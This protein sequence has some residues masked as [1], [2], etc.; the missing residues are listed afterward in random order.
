MYVRT[1]NETRIFGWLSSKCWPDVYNCCQLC[2]TLWLTLSMF[3][4]WLHPCPL[5]LMYLCGWSAIGSAWVGAH[6]ARG[7]FFHKESE[8][9]GH[10]AWKW[11]SCTNPICNKST[12]EKSLRIPYH[13]ILC[14][15]I[16]LCMCAYLN[17]R[18]TWYLVWPFNISKVY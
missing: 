12:G 7:F 16:M 11:Q 14:C 10:Y 18:S 1:D 9:I 4:F 3:F 6:A 8:G 2:L 17:L 5:W 15:S 13:L